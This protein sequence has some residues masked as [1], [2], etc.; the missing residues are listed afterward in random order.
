MFFSKNKRHDYSNWP[1]ITYS[2]EGV[3]F[4][5]PYRKLSGLGSPLNLLATTWKA[6]K[7]KIITRNFPF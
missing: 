3:T 4:Y 7:L 1:H 5:L 6:K 2:V